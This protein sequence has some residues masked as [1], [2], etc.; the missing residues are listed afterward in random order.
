MF[1]HVFIG[2]ADFERA[3]SFYRALMPVLGIR[4]RR[5]GPGPSRRSTSAT[6][7]PHLPE[8]PFAEVRCTISGILPA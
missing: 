1:S 3:L 4:E 7:W 2:V 8:C 6:S 5:A